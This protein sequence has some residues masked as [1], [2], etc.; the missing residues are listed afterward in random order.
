MSE[1]WLG[2]EVIFP[3]APTNLSAVPI[4]DKQIDLSW[5]DN[6]NNE[7]GFSIERKTGAS[8]YFQIRKLDSN[9]TSY[10]DQFLLNAG[11][12]YT[13]RIKAYHSGGAS[14]EYSNEVSATTLEDPTHV[15][16][17][18]LAAGPTKYALEQNYPNPF[19]PSTTIKYQLPE[20]TEVKLSVYNIQGQLI[21]L[22]VN[23]LQSSGYHQVDWQPINIPSG[24][25]IYKFETAEYI[26]I[27]KLVLIK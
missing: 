15:E 11:T 16:Q 19:N 13:Y 14:S 22:L 1:H 27:K 7:A 25:Y 18:M 20:L 6:A 9:I 26:Q 17:D 5:T 21:E 23:E 12:E 2:P 8:G 24:I 4:S 10:S 3:E